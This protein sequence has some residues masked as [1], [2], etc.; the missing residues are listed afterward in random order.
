M[1]ANWVHTKTMF[2]HI[3]EREIFFSQNCSKFAVE[4]D[5]NSKISQ[6][7]QKLGILEK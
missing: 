7:I 3:S 5:W 1:F 2:I 6:N 4:C